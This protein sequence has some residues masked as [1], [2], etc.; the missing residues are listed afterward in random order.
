MFFFYSLLL[1]RVLNGFGVE[2]ECDVQNRTKSKEQTS[3]CVPFTNFSFSNLAKT[4]EILVLEFW[5]LFSLCNNYYYCFVCQTLGFINDSCIQNSNCII[6]VP[7]N[8]FIWSF[9]I[10][11]EYHEFHFEYSVLWLLGWFFFILHADLKHVY[12]GRVL[13]NMN[14]SIL[15]K[16]FTCAISV[17]T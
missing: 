1:V 4:T 14:P 11:S 5:Q 3:L 13:S 15:L 6:L 17:C 10:I 9:D 12:S 2:I 7:F 16:W 8:S